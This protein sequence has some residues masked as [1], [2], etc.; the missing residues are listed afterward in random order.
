V[1]C[2]IADITLSIIS[3]VLMLFIFIGYEI[4]ARKKKLEKR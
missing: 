3:F 1:R 4:Y 2:F